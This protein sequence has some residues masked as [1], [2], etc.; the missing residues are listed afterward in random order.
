MLDDKLSQ[1]EVSDAEAREFFDQQRE[2]TLT[3]ATYEETETMIKQVL[4]NQKLNDELMSMV[5]QLQEQASIE[6]LI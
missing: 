4:K 5:S 2:A 3:N 6:I 1:I